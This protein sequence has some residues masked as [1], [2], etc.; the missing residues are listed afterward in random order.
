MVFERSEECSKCKKRTHTYCLSVWFNKAHVQ[1]CPHC[2]VEVTEDFA[3]QVIE[4]GQG[5]W[6][7]KNWKNWKNSDVHWQQYYQHEGD[8]QSDYDDDYDCESE[9]ASEDYAESGSQ[10]EGGASAE[11]S[12]GGS[13]SIDESAAPVS[14]GSDQ[15]GDDEL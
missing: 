12:E 9:S 10:G 1:K 15:V 13:E 8:D 4:A 7:A 5:E 2:R 3:L 11:G 14:S 6:E